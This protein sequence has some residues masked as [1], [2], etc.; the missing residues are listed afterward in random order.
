[1]LR[2]GNIWPAVFLLMLTSACSKPNDRIDIPKPLEVPFSSDLN[3]SLVAATVSYGGRVD[4]F[5]ARDFNENLDRLK[6]LFPEVMGDDVRSQPIRQEIIRQYVLEKLLINEAQQRG[7]GAD[8]AAVAHALSK[9]KQRFESEDAFL[10]ELEDIHQSEADLKA[11][12]RATLAREA[13]LKALQDSLEAPSDEAV[14]KF[15]QSMA[16][17]LRVQHILVGVSEDQTD[18]D[19]AESRAKTTRLIDSLDAGRPFAMLARRHSD[20]PGSSVS[21]GELPWFRRGDM[22]PE[23]ESSAFSLAEGKYTPR[24]V[25]TPYGFHII[26]LL[27]KQDDDAISLDSAKVL[28]IKRSVRQAHEDLQRNLVESALI[29]T[30]PTLIPVPDSTRN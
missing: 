29:R 6:M 5:L 10:A 30:N 9:Y 2:I 8:S 21:G 7:L 14:A 19:L 25:R 18:A 4:T 22:V 24:P 15:H 23:F 1:M 28:L 20:D 27:E 3:D 12:F 13:L 17:R 11:Q 26:K 16:T